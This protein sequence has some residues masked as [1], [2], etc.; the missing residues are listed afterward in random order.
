MRTSLSVEGSSRSSA[1]AAA[2]CRS[3]CQGDLDVRLDGG[4]G[5]QGDSHAGGQVEDAVGLEVAVA[6]HRAYQVRL[7]LLG[8]LRWAL[9]I[10]VALEGVYLRP[11][12]LA[13]QAADTL[14]DLGG[15]GVKTVA[16]DLAEAAHG[17]AL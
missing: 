16:Y 5:Q 4:Q 12:G 13:V 9:Q 11:H 14:P 17:A 3:S 2:R 15:F 10:L 6:E 8:H 1:S 7:L